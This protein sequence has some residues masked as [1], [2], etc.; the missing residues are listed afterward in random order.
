GAEPVPAHEPERQRV[1]RLDTIGS[2]DLD[3]LAVQLRL[4]V[5]AADRDHGVAVEP[6]LQSAGRHFE[7]RRARV[8]P[9]QHVRQPEGETI[10]RTCRAYPLI[11]EPLPP[12]IILDCRLN[13]TF[14]DFEH[15]DLLQ[16]LATLT[17]GLGAAAG[18]LLAYSRPLSGSPHL[19]DL[20][21]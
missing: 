17:P 1:S 16:S 10:H 7:P 11:E 12:R 13:P 5:R 21:H 8:V 14:K 15:P 18:I 2:P 3:R 4:H 6:D 9:H 20:R 19:G